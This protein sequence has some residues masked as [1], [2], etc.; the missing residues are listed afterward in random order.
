MSDLSEWVDLLEGEL[1]ERELEALRLMIRRS[2]VDRREFLRL[3]RLRDAVAETDPIEKW[4]EKIESPSYQKN[5]TERVMKSVRRESRTSRSL[6][7]DV[8][9]KIARDSSSS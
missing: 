5:F 6:R 4:R 9:V 3:S 2:T 1:D 8:P 7:K